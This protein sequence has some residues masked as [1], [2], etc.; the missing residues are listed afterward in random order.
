MPL[1]QDVYVPFLIITAV[2][3]AGVTLYS[4]Q[5]HQLKSGGAAFAVMM[6]GVGLWS[7]GYGFELAS[8]TLEDALFW[9]KVEY[10][11]I[12]TVP[13]A[14]LVLAS[15]Y[16]GKDKWVTSSNLA[17]FAIEPL[18]TIGLVWTSDTHGLI[19]THT[20][21]VPRGDAWALEVGHGL[22]FWV[23]LSYSYLVLTAG[24]LLILR[25]SLQ[26]R[27]VFGQQAVF[28]LVGASL[29]WVG[30]LA[31]VTHLSGAIDP[32]PFAFAVTGLVFLWAMISVRL[33]DIVPQA[34]DIIIDGLLEGVIV[35][36]RKGRIVNINKAANQAL[37]VSET[38]TIGKACA[39]VV[40]TWPGLAEQWNA[41]QETTTELA[42]SGS[43]EDHVFELTTNPLRD[44]LGRLNGHV[45]VL[46]DVTPVK[47]AA[48]SLSQANKVLERAVAER[49]SQIRTMNAELSSELEIRRETEAAL[50]HSNVRLEETLT[51]LRKTQQQMIQQERLRALGQMASGIAHDFNNA[52]VP[53]VGY[54]DLILEHPELFTTEGKMQPL[55][56]TINVAAKDA[57]NI[58]NRLREFYRFRE[59]GAYEDQIALAEVIEEAAQLTRPK[60]EKQ[61]Q[62]T[63]ADIAIIKNISAAPCVR[64]KA[65]ELREVLVNLIMN[66]VDAMPTGGTLTLGLRAAGGQVVLE[67]SDTGTGMTPEVRQRCLEPFFTTKD[68]QGTGLGLS[69]AYGIVQRH[70]GTIDIDSELGRG[71]TFSIRLPASEGQ[72]REM[73]DPGRHAYPTGL[74]IL[75][76]DDN[77]VA[78][79]TLEEYLR[80]DGHQV[81][82]A[83]DGVE[84]LERFGAQP[85]DVV[86]ANRA[87]PRMNGDN[88]AKAIKQRST[89]TPLIMLTGF[90]EMMHSLGEKPEGVDVVLGKPLTLLTLR[91]ALAK[92]SAMQPPAERFK[93]A[94]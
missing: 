90:G 55:L 70:G 57:A 72:D 50:Q 36:D 18:I 4:L 77:L 40:A 25:M 92:V 64:G 62:A 59:P 6:L 75:A 41:E 7:F 45:I 54:S 93:A 32:T 49:T 37:R 94:A 76:V 87:M 44:R 33:L 52:L 11:G 34:Q 71:T 27:K 29:P 2:A 60:W 30:N 42:G 53:I 23:H 47:R 88:L 85:F 28:L 3:C 69:M 91:T 12:A 31:Y 35:T 16:T 19:W 86:I 66:A 61:A 81:T 63:G 82:L 39:D 14:W 80:S 5:F 8:H 21:F 9:A 79:Q 17:L 24:T 13:L 38:G 74:R 83:R 43:L 22:W 58:V 56:R 46:K 78:L 20:A 51:E 26:S 68:E 15:Q 89:G 10:F 1:E 84:G 65:A 73:R 48:E 67:V